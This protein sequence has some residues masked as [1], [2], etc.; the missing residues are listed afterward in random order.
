M[1]RQDEY[2]EHDGI[3]GKVI[4]RCSVPQEEYQELIQDAPKEYVVIE[5]KEAVGGV[6][7]FGKYNDD[8]WSI[9]PWNTRTLVRILIENLNKGV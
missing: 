8:E 4:F 9:N 2:F 1:T 3:K 7:M 6:A 5:A